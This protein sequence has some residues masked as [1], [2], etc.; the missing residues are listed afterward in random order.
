MYD[1]IKKRGKGTQIEKEDTRKSVLKLFAGVFFPFFSSLFHF[2]MMTIEKNSIESSKKKKRLDVEGRKVAAFPYSVNLPGRVCVVQL[3]CSLFSDHEKKL[4]CRCK[5]VCVQLR[6][7]C[8]TSS[9]CVSVACGGPL[10]QKKRGS[11]VD[12][13][14]RCS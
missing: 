6:H 9:V 1:E 10:S 8:L 14:H 3:Q 7:A 4:V 12:A 11:G 13:K 5:H 2:A